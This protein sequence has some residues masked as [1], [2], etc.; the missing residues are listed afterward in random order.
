MADKKF[1]A[2]FSSRGTVK[3]T[4]KLLIHN[5]D[6][7]ATEF[8][9]VAALHGIAYQTPVFANPLILD[10]TYY[11]N[12]APATITGDCTIHIHNSVD[13]D[14]GNILLILDG[15]GGYT[16]DVDSKYLNIIIGDAI[17][18]LASGVNLIKWYNVITI[19]Q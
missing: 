15:T 5:I 7:G 14:S 16:L 17:N 4:D 19:T 6:T 3:P 12:F 1:P 13:G 2:D 10:A 9:T 8:T 11:K 18:G